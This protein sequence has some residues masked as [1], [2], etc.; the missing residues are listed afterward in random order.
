MYVR[1][2]YFSVRRTRLSIDLSYSF[3]WGVSAFRE[4]EFWSRGRVF[5]L[6]WKSSRASGASMIESRR[7]NEHATIRS[8]SP[9]TQWSFRKRRWPRRLSTVPDSH[10]GARWPTEE[11][12]TE[13]KSAPLSI[14]Y[15]ALSRIL[16]TT[17]C[18][19]QQGGERQDLINTPAR[20]K[21]FP[22][23][24]PSRQEISTHKNSPRDDSTLLQK[25][26]K[27]ELLCL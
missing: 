21:K 13:S 7:L 3:Y 26:L 20:I 27:V 5:F 6:A 15:K 25:T 16:T 22:L 4:G 1:K 19:R 9:I 10:S 11:R 2:I 23:Y 24:E 17:V 8:C 14:I 12:K 18:R